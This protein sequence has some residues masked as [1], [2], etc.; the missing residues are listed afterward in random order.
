MAVV[1]ERAAEKSV[2]V[3]ETTDLFEGW[4]A[5]ATDLAVDMDEVGKYPGLGEAIDA[6]FLK[7]VG[8]ESRKMTD[9][10]KKKL[11]RAARAIAWTIGGR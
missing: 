1:L 8:D 10:D 4:H 2:R 3:T 9:L 7:A 6:V 5:A 11:A